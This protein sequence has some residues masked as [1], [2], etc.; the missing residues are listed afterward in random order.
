M[1]LHPPESLALMPTRIFKIALRLAVVLCMAW[2]VHLL[3][4]WAMLESTSLAAEHRFNLGVITA[5]LLCYALLIAVPF[6]PGVELG[7]SL[8][9]L[10]GPPAAPWVWGATV[11]GL[12]MAFAAGAWLPVGLIASGMRDLGLRRAAKLVDAVAPL[13]PQGRVDLLCRR[14]PGW[15]TP[16][17]LKHR[18]ILLSLLINIPGNALVGGGG[19]IGL[20]AG[21]SRIYAPLPTVLTFIIAV[22]PVPLLF[23]FYGVPVLS[24]F[25]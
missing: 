13:D 19:G 18:Y 5:L 15:L 3:A 21:L 8:L 20:I 17:A 9:L 16:L 25:N 10:Q 22:S 24:L 6:V 4:D 2:G 11:V 7:L 1:G 23:W 14:L 12:T